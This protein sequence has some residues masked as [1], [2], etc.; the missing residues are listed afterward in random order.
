MRL[1][2]PPLLPLSLSAPFLGYLS[3]LKL[4]GK[5]KQGF[6]VTNRARNLAQK[7]VH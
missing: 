7:A 3:F 4:N 6:E 2:P 5:E 1:F